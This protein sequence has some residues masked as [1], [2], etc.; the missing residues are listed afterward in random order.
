MKREEGGEQLERRDS[1]LFDGKGFFFLPLLGLVF[2]ARRV[3]L[4]NNSQSSPFW[5]IW[6]IKKVAMEL[7]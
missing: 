7:T 1:K 3:L 4:L 5:L 6:F 2:A